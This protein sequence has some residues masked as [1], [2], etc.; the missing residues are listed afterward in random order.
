MLRMSK[1]SQ[2][3][4]RKYKVWRDMSAIPTWLKHLEQNVPFATELTDLLMLTTLSDD[5]KP[6]TESWT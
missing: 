5:R 3:K 6:P 1:K 4:W 2:Q